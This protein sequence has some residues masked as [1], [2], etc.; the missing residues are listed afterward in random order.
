MV[1]NSDILLQVD[2]LKTHFFTDEGQEL[3]PELQVDV[4]Q[5]LVQEHSARSGDQG[6]CQ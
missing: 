4:D 6:A 2:G 1:V 5:G 3:G